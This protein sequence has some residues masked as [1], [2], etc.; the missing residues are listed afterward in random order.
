MVAKKKQ[1][2]ILG[3]LMR[4]TRISWDWRLAEVCAKMKISKATLSDIENGNSQPRFFTLRAWAKTIG[5]SLPHFLM[6]FENELKDAEEMLKTRKRKAN[7][8]DVVEA[9]R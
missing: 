1:I 4:T 7:Q 5:I 2:K 3:D 9:S 6:R 8:A